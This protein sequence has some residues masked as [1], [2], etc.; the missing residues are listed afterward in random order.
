M[1]FV[2]E[3]GET[4]AHLLGKARLKTP[5]P[6]YLQLYRVSRLQTIYVLHFHVDQKAVALLHHRCV[7]A[8][9]PQPTFCSMYLF[10]WISPVHSLELFM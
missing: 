1:P 3:H 5:Y 2:L 9:R 7:T 10:P 8:Q 6:P 4:N